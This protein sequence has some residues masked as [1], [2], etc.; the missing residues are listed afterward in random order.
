MTFWLSFRK[1]ELVKL[2]DSLNIPL[3]RKVPVVF[4]NEI[5]EVILG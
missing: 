3:P 2:S 4:E 5:K 1:D